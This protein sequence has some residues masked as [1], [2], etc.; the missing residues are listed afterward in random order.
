MNSIKQIVT[1]TNTVTET[2]EEIQVSRRDA[3]RR[4]LLMGTMT[5]GGV[6][7]LAGCKKELQ[8]SDT[9][10]LAPADVQMRTTLHYVDKSTMADK[11]CENCNFYKAAPAND[12]CGGCLLIKGT[13]HPK[14]N[15]DSWAKKA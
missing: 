10:G 6:W 7:L 13:V 15:C 14:G 5:V 11:N 4:S 2:K 1:E 3:L 12:Q 8:C 9:A